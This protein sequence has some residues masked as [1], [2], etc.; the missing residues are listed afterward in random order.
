MGRF[1]NDSKHVWWW[2]FPQT[3]DFLCNCYSVAHVKEW[4]CRA[5]KIT[6]MTD[7]VINQSKKISCLLVWFCQTNMFFLMFS[8][9]LSI[10]HLRFTHPKN[11]LQVPLAQYYASPIGRTKLHQKSW[12][13]KSDQSLDTHNDGHHL[14]S[15]AG[16]VLFF[17]FTHVCIIYIYT[18]NRSWIPALC[19]RLSQFGRM[20]MAGQACWV[21]G[22]RISRLLVFYVSD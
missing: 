4:T 11:M 1:Q 5:K 17:I 2:H 10:L 20:L 18:A 16:D 19:F 3:S 6:D 15:S 9:L 7:L 21:F 22:L 13:L 8:R 12:D 14:K